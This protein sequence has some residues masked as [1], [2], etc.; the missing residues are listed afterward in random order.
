[1]E[2]TT[3]APKIAVRQV[4]FSARNLPPPDFEILYGFGQSY[5]RESGSPSVDGTLTTDQVMKVGLRWTPRPKDL[6]SFEAASHVVLRSQEDDKTI[7]ETAADLEVGGRLL[8][9]DREDMGLALFLGGLAEVGAN[10]G[11]ADLLSEYDPTLMQRYG[12]AARLEAPFKKGNGKE[13]FKLG[14][15]VDGGSYT[16]GVD[17]ITRTGLYYAVTAQ[18]N[19]RF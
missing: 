9:F 10:F 15:G 18:L 3:A 7:D 13:V 17:P 6:L 1:M 4:S 8:L 12:A 16:V 14:L 11:G 5:F 2:P 19:L